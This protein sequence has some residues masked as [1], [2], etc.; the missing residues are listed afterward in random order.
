MAL[1]NTKLSQ[2]LLTASCVLALG[3]SG[4][5]IDRS[6]LG[7]GA[8]GE[9]TGPTD[10][11][12]SRPDAYVDPATDADLDAFEPDA[13]ADDAFSVDASADAFAADACVVRC[14]DAETIVY[15]EG[16]RSESTDTCKYGCSDTPA[17]H[18]R[19]MVTSNLR[20][21]SIFDTASGDL[22]VSESMTID[23]SMMGDMRSQRDGT[24][25]RVLVYE[26]I[27]IG[28]NLRVIGPV[29]LILIAR[30]EITIGGTLDVSAMGSMP[31]P[32]G[33][34]GA[35]SSGGSAS[36]PGAGGGGEHR[37]SYDDG[38]GGGGGQCGL[39][40]R[41][42]VGGGAP[43]GDGG[44]RTD[45]AVDPESLRGGGGGGAGN[46]DHGVGGAGGGAIQLST[47]GTITIG[48]SVLARGSNGGNGDNDGNWGS[49]GGGGAGGWV[50]LEAPAVIV[51]GTIDASGG[52]G[53]SGEDGGGGGAGGAST[54]DGATGGSDTGTWGNGGG[55]GGGAGCIVVR[56]SGAMSPTMG[57]LRP[58][59]GGLLRLPLLVE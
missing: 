59:D 27:V 16:S 36:G 12:A 1:S 49:G 11:D 28:N 22:V 3:A 10:R 20:S 35:G 40:G 25:V 56:S 52:N 55:G 44:G 6:A 5:L 30:D 58:S 4:C 54:S 41:G 15:C 13:Y 14:L 48:G 34:A 7:G 50:L 42:G 38:G 17:A 47:R 21:A 9:D 19:E 2:A 31:G 37:G 43:G 23:T 24:P 26:R 51:S 18:C 33:R 53:G 8:S 29:P 45:T 46:G 57:M 39:G 32:N